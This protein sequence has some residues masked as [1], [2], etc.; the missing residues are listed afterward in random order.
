MKDLKFY[1]DQFAELR[2]APGPVW[3]EAT[4]KQA[5]HKPLL[6]LGIIDLISRGVIKSSFIDINGD[7]NELNDL[8][9]AYWRRVVPLSQKSSIAFPFSRLHNESFW[10][11]IPVKGKE[12]TQTAINNIS[13]ISQLREIALGAMIDEDLFYHLNKLDTRNALREVLL[14]GYFSGE[15]SDQLR[16]Q[17][18][19]HSQA[20]GYSQELERVAHMPLVQ[21]T[22]EQT[23]FTE[24]VRD[25]GFRR[26]LVKAYDHRCAL[27][28][29]RIITPE[30]H[31]VVDAAHI[32][33]WNVGHNDDIRN[34]LALCK[35]CHWAF[36]KGMLGIS[37]DYEVITSGHINTNPNIPGFF[38]TLS[39]RKII[40][41]AEKVLWPAKEYLQWHRKQILFNTGSF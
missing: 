35:I 39:D 26:A 33:P 16:E 1:I 5:P 28:G 17:I 30:G 8:F 14:N 6:L 13:N 31:T 24:E 19:I 41:P 20:F 11:L 25:Q 4:K 34:G 22:M 3:T 21:Q 15:A 27:C 2:R 12:I 23:Q 18:A 32:Q 38:L 40:P 10:K 36:D 9:T 37:D 29:V 7:L